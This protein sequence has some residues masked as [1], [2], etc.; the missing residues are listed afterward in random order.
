MFFRTAED[1]SFMRSALELARQAGCMGEIPVGAVVV[2][3]GQIIGRGYNQREVLRSPLA[4]AELI[5]IQEASRALNSWRLTGCSLYVT[6]EPCPMC[7]GA[8]VNARIQRLVYG[9]FDPKGGCCGSLINLLAL[10][11][12]HQTAIT[13]PVLEQECSQLLEQFFQGLRA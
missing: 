12:P 5:A 2:R 3:E 13:A 1:E 7:A 10:E 8:I 6:L 11:L 4:H 9:A